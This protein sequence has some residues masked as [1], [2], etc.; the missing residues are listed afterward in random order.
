[1]RAGCAS[2]AVAATIVMLSSGA[3]GNSYTFHDLLAPSYTYQGINAAS[4][5]AQVGYSSVAGTNHAGMWSGTAQ[6]FVDLHPAGYTLSYGTAAGAGTQ[7]GWVKGPATGENTHAAL[8]FD[9]A[10]SMVDLHP[11]GGFTHSYVSAAA[12]NQQAGNVLDANE[13]SY[14]FLWTSSAASAVNLHPA[15][16]DQSDVYGMSATQQVGYAEEADSNTHAMFWSGTAASAVDLTPVTTGLGGWLHGTAGNQQVG[17]VYDRNAPPGAVTVRAAMW[18]GTPDSIVDLTTTPQGAT[19]TYS[20]VLATNGTQQ[21]GE[22]EMSPGFWPIGFLW[23]GSADS[24]VNLEQFVPDE[25]FYVRPL[26]ILDDG[27]IYGTANYLVEG[28]SKAHPFALVPTVPEPATAGALA[29][30]VGLALCR[31]GAG[32]ANAGRR[33]RR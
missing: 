9:S 28:G 13:K 16:F 22:V 32:R 7:A 18:S 31:R 2:V 27:T 4:S 33:P 15:G 11:A 3:R 8:W 19:W 23:S 17:A 12:G 14:A 10:A 21:V 25:Y 20:D 26:A 29:L 30:I 24:A 5:N 1:M 6:S